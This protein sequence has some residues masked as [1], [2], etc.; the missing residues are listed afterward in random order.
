MNF[1]IEPPR[2][3]LVCALDWGLGHV[4]RT[5]PLVRALLAGGSRVTLASNGRSAAWWRAEFPD[6]EVRGLPDYGVR[7]APGIWLVPGLLGSLPRIVGAIRAEHALVRRWQQDDRFDLVLSDNRYGCRAPDTRSI[8][9]TH[10]LRLPAPRGLGWSEP[11]GERLVARLTRPFQEIWVPDRKDGF[12]LSGKLGH[13]SRAASFP[14]LRHIGPLSRFAGILPDPAWAGPW[15]TVALVSGPEPSRTCF[16]SKLRQILSQRPGRHLLVR[17][18]PDIPSTSLD[19]ARSDLLEAPH[20]PSPALAAALAGAREII[21]RGGYSTVMDLDALGVLDRRCLFVPTPGQTEQE[22]LAEHLA[23][24]HHCRTV[25]ES[26][27][28]S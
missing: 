19:P 1:P 4:A 24:S 18:R 10:Q 23:T 17:G 21:C 16:E 3:T 27:L 12:C 5:T 13:P 6:L 22:Y 9:I 7:Y 26:L 8:F 15:D 14:P 11:L 2:S 20:L 25:A 28:G